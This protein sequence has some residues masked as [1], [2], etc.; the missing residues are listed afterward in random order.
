MIICV[1]EYLITR[2]SKSNNN[3]LEST[4]RH[5]IHN[6]RTSKVISI[7]I[8]FIC[9]IT[10]VDLNRTYG[11]SFPRNRTHSKSQPLDMENGDGRGLIRLTTIH[12]QT[13]PPGRPWPPI[14]RP[15]PTLYFPLCFQQHP[16]P[17]LE[18][19]PAVFKLLKV[20]P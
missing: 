13:M 5:I 6:Y 4:H 11:H 9:R 2:A 20:Y 10:Q 1:G 15:Q 8:L 19:E 18:L 16:H 7:I 14:F 3:R 17:T 12:N